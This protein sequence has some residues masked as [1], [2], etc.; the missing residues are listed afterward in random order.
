MK[1]TSDFYKLLSQK[2]PQ[3]EMQQKVLEKIAATVALGMRSLVVKNLDP[4]DEKAFEQVVE[5]EDD[6]GIFLF[7]QERV[8]NFEYKFQLLVDDISQTV[9]ADLTS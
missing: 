3:K 5:K 1:N 4:R 9:S 2:F 7:A 6:L 8:D